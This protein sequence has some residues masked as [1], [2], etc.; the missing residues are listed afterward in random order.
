MSN[1]GFTKTDREPIDTNYPCPK[2]DTHQFPQ[3][4][5]KID[6]DDRLT[7]NEFLAMDDLYHIR[8]RFLRHKM[9]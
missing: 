2:H 8:S 4:F 9:K 6:A 5:E 7:N 1:K 3:N